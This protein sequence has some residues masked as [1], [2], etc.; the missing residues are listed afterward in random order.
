VV[1]DGGGGALGWDDGRGEVERAVSVERRQ[2]SVLALRVRTSRSTRMTAPTRQDQ[3]GSVK[4]C[5]VSKTV[6]LRSS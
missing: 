5:A 4:A 3:S 6:T 1:S 2:R